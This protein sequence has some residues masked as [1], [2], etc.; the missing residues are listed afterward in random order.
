MDKSLIEKYKNQMLGMYRS[1]KHKPSETVSAT[2]NITE[3]PLSERTENAAFDSKP[4]GDE[5]GNLVIIVS[6]LRS[7]YPL[8]NAKVTVFKGEINNMEVLET[9]YTDQ[10][11]RT[12]N[13]SLSAPEA[14]LSQESDYSGKPYSAYNIMVNAEGFRDNIHLNI[15]VFSG[16]TTLQR[17]NMMLLETSGEDKGPQIY[18]ES[19]DFNL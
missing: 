8:P 10:S 15:P 11:G 12:P 18:D 1:V 2:V 3:P 13:I 14:E 7:L 4:Y 6:T 19:E 5:K 17:S 9:V 16:V